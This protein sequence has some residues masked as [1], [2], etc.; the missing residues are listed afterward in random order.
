MTVRVDP[1]HLPARG[2]SVGLDVNVERVH[3]FDPV[4]ADAI[5]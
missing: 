3:F 5:R 2:Q 4:S 1:A